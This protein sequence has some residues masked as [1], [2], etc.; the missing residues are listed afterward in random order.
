MNAKYYLYEKIL[1]IIL[2]VAGLALATGCDLTGKATGSGT[3]CSDS[4]VISGNTLCPS[5]APMDA[6]C[7]SY[8]IYQAG[9]VIM[10]QS[11]KTVVTYPD[12][13]VNGVLTEY[14]CQYRG[15]GGAAES[16]TFACAC[17]NGAC[18]CPP[19]SCTGTSRCTGN[20]R[21]TC[22]DS[23][24][25]GCRE[26][27]VAETC[28][29]GCSNGACSTPPST[30]ACSHECS[31]SYTT[32][33]QGSNKMICQDSD[34]DGCLEWNLAQSCTNGCSNGECSLPT[35][36]TYPPTTLA[37][38]TNTCSSQG[39]KVCSGK[40]IKTCTSGANGCLSWVV[41]TACPSRCVAGVCVA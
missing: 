37:P 14:Y 16:K 3:T 32:T 6:A 19:G 30:T 28:A 34:A 9:T 5:G 35:G 22:S 11:G 38:C 18:P 41:G 23:N 2:L 7:T 15:G 39:L 25:D 21:E 12:A 40:S 4:D 10:T 26:W 13:C 29:Y 27:S 24:S 8:N 20:N 31:M 36:T 1:V 17:S 33:C